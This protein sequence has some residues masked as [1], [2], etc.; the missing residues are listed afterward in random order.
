ML[1][2]PEFPIGDKRFFRRFRMDKPQLPGK[3]E[4]PDITDI[5]RQLRMGASMAKYKILHD[6]F[7][8]NDAAW[9]MLDVEQSG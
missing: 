8:I 6:E 1:H 3:F 7:N 2:P 5:I 4:Q 9:I